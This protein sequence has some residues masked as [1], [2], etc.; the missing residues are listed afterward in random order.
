MISFY[1]PKGL[2]AWLRSSHGYAIKANLLAEETWTIPRVLI[3][4]EGNCVT[5]HVEGYVVVK[6]VDR[7]IVETP[8]GNDLAD[9]MLQEKIGYFWR[10]VH[11]SVNYRMTF[12]TNSRSIS[13]RAIEAF[14]LRPVR[15]IKGMDVSSGTTNEK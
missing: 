10:D 6:H 14:L 4:T 12:W 3:V 11:W 8:A 7:P 9:E 2:M 1:G 5:V 15:W 13:Q